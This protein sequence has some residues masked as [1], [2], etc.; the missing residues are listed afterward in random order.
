MAS[1]R[2]ESSKRPRAPESSAAERGHRLV[3]PPLGRL[4][5]RAGDLHHARVR[6]R[7]GLAPAGGGSSR[8]RASTGRPPARSSDEVDAR[9]LHRPSCAAGR[10]GRRRRAGPPRAGGCGRRRPRRAAGTSRRSCQAGF[11]PGFSP[12]RVSP[13]CGSRSIPPWTAAITTSGL[14][15]ASARSARRTPSSGASNESPRMLLRLLPLRDGRGRDPDDRDLHAGH[16]L[17]DVRR[18]RRRPRRGAVLAESQGKR[19]AFRAASRLPRPKL[20]SWLP[21]TMAS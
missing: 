10:E 19:A 7:L 2:A 21:T 9:H 20:N 3:E 12:G 5:V 18:E 1:T 11:S 17:H 14:S 4:V 6:R 8:P 15:R 13:V 16:G